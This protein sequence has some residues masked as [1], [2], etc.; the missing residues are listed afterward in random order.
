MAALLACGKKGEE[1]EAEQ[2][3]EGMSVWW[4]IEWLPKSVG[5]LS[6]KC[7]PPLPILSYHFPSLALC[8]FH[9]LSLFFSALR[10]RLNTFLF[11]PTS[12]SDIVR[13]LLPF[14]IAAPLLKRNGGKTGGKRKATSARRDSH[15]RG[16]RPDAPTD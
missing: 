15:L 4:S 8:R 3:K 12:L 9:P 6:S 2:G 13:L 1:E 10:L 11:S 5:G 14:R 7:A 16:R